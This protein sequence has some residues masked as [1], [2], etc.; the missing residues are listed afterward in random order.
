MTTALYFFTLNP[1]PSSPRPRVRLSHA[2]SR[3]L[4]ER[5]WHSNALTWQVDWRKWRSNA[6][7]PEVDAKSR[8][9]NPCLWELGYFGQRIMD[10]RGL[11][12]RAGK[13]QPAKEQGT[14]ILQR[15]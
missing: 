6:L 1:S 10:A 4:G 3:R 13:A 15:P 9:Y 7:F 11:Q 2:F 8:T 12:R 14:S 5:R